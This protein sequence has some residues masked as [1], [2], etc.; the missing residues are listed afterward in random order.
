MNLLD[1]DTPPPP[2]YKQ[3]IQLE[4]WYLINRGTA[5]LEALEDNLRE[6]QKTLLQ[7]FVEYKEGNGAYF[8]PP[9]LII[10]IIG[11]MQDLQRGETEGYF[12][13][14]TRPSKRPENHPHIEMAIEQAVRYVRHHQEKAAG[15]NSPK[16]IQ[17]VC[18]EYKVKPQTVRT[19]V[20][21]PKYKNSATTTVPWSSLEQGRLAIQVMG[22]IYRNSGKA[23]SVD[24]INRKQRKRKG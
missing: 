11:A 21:I 24:A 12:K 3:F 17:D 5:T 14:F 2:S 4:D 18:D 15:F 19:W 1:F 6:R 7:C 23:S 10:T 20:K 22:E 13:P 16:Y 9:R 8:L